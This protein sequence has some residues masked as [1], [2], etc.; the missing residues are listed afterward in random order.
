MLPEVQD[1][2]LKIT[3]SCANINEFVSRGLRYG[4]SN[5]R[6]PRNRCAAVRFRDMK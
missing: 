2:T 3:E 1:E 5:V 6:P 4:F